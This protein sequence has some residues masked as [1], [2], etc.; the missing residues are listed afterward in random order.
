MNVENGVVLREKP[1]Q[2]V[3]DSPIACVP[4][5]NCIP[6]STWIGQLPKHMPFCETAKGTP[7]LDSEMEE[8]SPSQLTHCSIGT[9]SDGPYST[10]ARRPQRF[11][12]KRAR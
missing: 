10:W 3:L 9:A 8:T 1:Q 6:P 2:K 12:R 11:C 4:Q 5:K 7:R